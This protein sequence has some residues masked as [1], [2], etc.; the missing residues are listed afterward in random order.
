[1]LTCW[2][3]CIVVLLLLSYIILYSWCTYFVGWQHPI[4]HVLYKVMFLDFLYLFWQFFPQ[5]VSISDVCY[6]ITNLPIGYECR[7]IC[8][9]SGVF[10][11]YV[12]EALVFDPYWDNKVP[13]L[14][15]CA[16]L[17]YC[18]SFISHPIWQSSRSQPHVR[19]VVCKIK[20]F[21]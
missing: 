11:K 19:S 7:N 8:C 16:C 5:F 18:D 4:T 12:S 6:L 21:K 20:S 1:M 13:S 14:D 9:E 3:T 17:H 15:L 2:W 10:W